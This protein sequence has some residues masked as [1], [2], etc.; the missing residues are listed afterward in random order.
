MTYFLCTLRCHVLFLLI[1][2]DLL[3][4][5]PCYSSE[6]VS[7]KHCHVFFV[8]FFWLMIKFKCHSEAHVFGNYYSVVLHFVNFYYCFFIFIIYMSISTRI[9]GFSYRNFWMNRF[10]FLERLNMASM[11]RRRYLISVIRIVMYESCKISKIKSVNG[12]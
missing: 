5:L 2:S 3:F 7:E 12:I 4:P 8:F 1:L 11:E 6:Q 9:V 10:L